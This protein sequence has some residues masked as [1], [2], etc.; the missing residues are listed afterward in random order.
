MEEIVL[1]VPREKIEKED[2]GEVFQTIG[3]LM[4]SNCSPYQG[5]LS[6]EILGYEDD[7]ELFEIEEVRQ[8]YKKLDNCLPFL[9]YFLSKKQNFIYAAMFVPF[10]LCSGKAVFD[11]EILKDWAYAKIDII[12]EL[13]EYFGINP[14][15]AIKDFSEDIG[16]GLLEDFYEFFED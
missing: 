7:R 15:K 4:V 10:S 2:I 5:L 16:L 8:W 9:P 14:K 12:V 11:Q 3:S 6:I 13:C 1:N